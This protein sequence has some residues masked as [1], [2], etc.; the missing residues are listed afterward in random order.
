MTR[1]ILKRILLLVC[2]IVQSESLYAQF[3][4]GVKS[5]VG[6]ANS[7]QIRA[8]GYNYVSIPDIYSNFQLILQK[9]TKNNEHL[10]LSFGYE[11]LHTQ[12]I[13][14][15]DYVPTSEYLPP[16]ST[17]CYDVQR[18]VNYFTVNIGRY[19]SFKN[20]NIIV[21]YNLSNKFTENWLKRNDHKYTYNLAL[22][23][24]VVLKPS[25]TTELG[26]DFAHDIIP[27]MWYEAFPGYNAQFN[28]S[29]NV[30]FTY[31]IHFKQ[32]QNSDSN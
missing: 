16:N 14:I 31:M 32:K 12:G 5:S 20:T 9:E 26:I 19:K 10:F 2:T 28:Y 11:Y 7:W 3:S 24:G 13:I 17:I 23:A 1:L 18:K 6:M 4:L 15:S 27:Y 22:S 21:Q 25:K 29:V 8:S 30:S